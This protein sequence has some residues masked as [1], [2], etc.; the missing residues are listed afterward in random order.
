MS[1]I[2]ELQDVIHHL[3][4]AKATHVENVPIT[5]KYHGQVVWDG[6]VEV[7]RLRG[8]PQT[9]RIY[10]WAHDTEDPAN[11]KRYVTV[12]HLPPVVSPLT[13]VQAVIAQE[14]RE[15]DRNKEN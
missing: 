7:F 5:E 4:G 8:H 13:A 12:L 3:H 11:Q 2:Q 6:V 9:N 1:Y 15:R 10:A 14:L